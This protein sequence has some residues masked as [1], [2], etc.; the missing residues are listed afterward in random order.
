MLSRVI[1]GTQTAIL[2]I[3]VAVVLSIFI[4]VALGLYGGYFGGWLDSVMVV[5]FDAIYAFP[6]LLLAIVL[7]IV[8]SGGQ[9]SLWGG[10]L[11]AAVS[12]IVVFIPQYFRVIRAETVRIKAEA[13]VESAKV[14]GASSTRIMFQHVFRNATRTLPLIV[15]LNSVGGD[16]DPGGTRLHRL[17]NRADGRGRVGLR[18][19]QGPV[20]RHER[21]LVDRPVPRA[22]DRA[23]GARHHARRR[24]PQRPRRPAPARLAGASRR[25]SGQ[26]GG[27]LGRPRRHADGRPRRHRRSRGRR[28]IRR[29]RDRGQA[30]STVVDIRNLGVSFAT[31][32]GAV[33]AVDDVSLSVERGEVL[34]IVG[35]SGS[36]KTVTAK[37]I[38]GLLP[39]T[40]TTTRRRHPRESGGDPRERRHQRLEAEARATCAAPTSRWCSRSRRRR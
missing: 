20:R 4:G 39:E 35:E 24:E 1:W 5:V 34:A 28:D 7:A 38:L 23:R 2:V 11:A 12:I 16:P 8:I 32:A 36:G 19:E 17:R 15:T 10:I 6:S 40:A 29:A 30:M 25:P 14:L 33:K 37:T 22:R 27:D 3:I 13:Y 9:S 18:P 31:D 26:V 21:H